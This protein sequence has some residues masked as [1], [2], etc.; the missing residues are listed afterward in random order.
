MLRKYFHFF[1]ASLLSY[2]TSSPTWGQEFTYTPM[3]TLAPR[4]LLQSLD[5]RLE[6]DIKAIPSK[7]QNEIKEIY[8]NRVEILK[9]NIYNNHYAFGNQI[10]DYLEY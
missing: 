4:V 3:R 5:S 1:I 8:S 6:K 10:N 2:M 9:N 7:Y